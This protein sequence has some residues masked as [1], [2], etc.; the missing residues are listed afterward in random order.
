M[1][2]LIHAATRQQIPE[3][4]T[5]P[6][7]N[8][9]NSATVSK[10]SC[11]AVDS[12]SH[13]S[14]NVQTIGVQPMN[15]DG[16]TPTLR[17]LAPRSADQPASSAIDITAARTS[18]PPDHPPQVQVSV[19][20]HQALPNMVQM[21]G[22]RLGDCVTNA[23]K[24]SMAAHTDAVVKGV[25]EALPKGKGNHVA[26]TESGRDDEDEITSERPRN[27]RSSG[28]KSKGPRGAANFLHVSDCCTLRL[29]HHSYPLLTGIQH[30]FRIFLRSKG[31]LP[32]KNDPLPTQVSEDVLRSFDRDGQPTPDITNVRL[33]WTASLIKSK[34]NKQTTGLLAEAFLLALQAGEYP[35]VK[36]DSKTMTI[37]SLTKM[38]AEKLNRVHER[39]HFSR[40]AS[41]TID[42]TILQ[43]IHE[44]P[45]RQLTRSRRNTRRQNVC[46]YGDVH[47][48]TVSLLITQTYKRRQRI[49]AENGN[50]DPELWSQI[51]KVLNRLDVQGMSSDESDDEYS[52]APIVNP[53]PQKRLRRVRLQWLNQQITD[54][55][56]AVETYDKTSIQHYLRRGNLP[57]YRDPIAKQ[58][59]TERRAIPCLPRNWYDDNWFKGLHHLDQMLLGAAAEEPIP[60]LVCTSYLSHYMYSPDYKF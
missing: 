35:E 50:T 3:S 8:T 12:L 34:W 55:F 37:D 52:R 42:E 28:R 6:S 39:A 36:Y 4:Q 19:S 9:D 2:C 20:A 16:D 40:V 59:N 17:P 11:T 44:R 14:G 56:V 24:S 10:L 27:L 46:H 43:A 23:I 1:S 7:T 53:R 26:S 48:F 30:A 49:V 29:T 15:V 41:E 25:V 32:S 18:H 33:D 45:Q 13:P 21:L 57:L 47:L 54:L 58:I 22:D 5:G 38:C 60:V 31:L 51:R